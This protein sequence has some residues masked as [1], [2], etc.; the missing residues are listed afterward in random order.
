MLIGQVFC[1]GDNIPVDAAQG[2]C[3][4]GAGQ[5]HL[6]RRS[7]NAPLSPGLRDCTQPLLG[8]LL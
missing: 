2:Y 1:R 6:H 8:Q 7:W 5:E 4:I 3:G